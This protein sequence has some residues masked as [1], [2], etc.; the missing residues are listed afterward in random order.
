M[1]L[2]IP[3]GIQ[4]L[5]SDYYVNYSGSEEAAKFIRTEFTDRPIVAVGSGMTAILP[6][7]PE[8]EFFYPYLGEYGT[9]Q[10]W[11]EAYGS[12]I[13]VPF[14]PFIG[15]VYQVFPEEK[16]YILITNDLLKEELC[17][18]LVY[19]T[20]NQVMRPEIF[21]LYEPIEGCELPSMEEWENQLI[22]KEG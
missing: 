21:F 10:T 5:Q 15:Y 14:Q 19:R 2:S 3:L 20:I 17:Y 11:T 9:F 18:R 8:M 6:Y 22:K 7:L 4:A 13:N 16:P 12:A 1:A